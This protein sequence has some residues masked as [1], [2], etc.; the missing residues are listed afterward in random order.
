MIPRL[1]Q[2]IH[3]ARQRVKG[4]DTRVEGEIVSV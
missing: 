2:V 3:Q 4:G 1:E